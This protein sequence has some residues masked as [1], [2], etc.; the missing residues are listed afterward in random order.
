MSKK[1]AKAVKSTPANLKERLD[2]LTAELKELQ[3]EN[4]AVKEQGSKGCTWGCDESD[5][6]GQRCEA[7]GN[8]RIRCGYEWSA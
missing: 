6:G 1:A 3:S 7:S 2:H 8:Q 4:E 5:P